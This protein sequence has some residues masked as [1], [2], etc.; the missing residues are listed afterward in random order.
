ME[1]MNA[2]SRLKYYRKKCNILG[3]AE[4]AEILGGTKQQ[5]ANWGRRKK[6]PKPDFKLAATPC[7]WVMTIDDWLK[8]E[9]E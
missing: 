5:V 4:L 2:K 9:D 7:W 1:K 8:E 3:F 6:L